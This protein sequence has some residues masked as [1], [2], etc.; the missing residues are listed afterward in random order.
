MVTSAPFIIGSCD[1]LTLDLTLSYGNGGHDWSAV[2]IIVSDTLNRNLSALQYFLDTK[3]KTPT[4]IPSTLIIAKK[5]SCDT[6]QLFD[7]VQLIKYRICC[8]R[9]SKARVKIVGGPVRQM[10]RSSLFS[11]TTTTTVV[12]CG[13]QRSSYALNY[14]WMLNKG[15]VPILSVVS[16]SKDPSKFILSPSF[17]DVR[18]CPVYCESRSY[19]QGV[20]QIIN[21]LSER[22]CE[23]RRDLRSHRRRHRSIPSY[24]LFDDD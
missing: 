22:D 12:N 24:G 23:Y 19:H 7:R 3:Y 21:V 13:I 17:F 9:N 10:I 5:R 2:K 15:G 4:L 18:W 14:Q 1:N 8:L 16:A 11:L 6:V 20:V